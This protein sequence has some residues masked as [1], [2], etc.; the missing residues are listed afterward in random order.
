M[1]QATDAYI[2]WYQAQQDA[3]RSATSDAQ[4]PGDGSAST[5]AEE[6]ALA[7]VAALV[8]GRTS[9]G[10]APATDAATAASEFLSSL[11]QPPGGDESRTR[12]ARSMREQDQPLEAAFEVLRG[13]LH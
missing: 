2:Q 3:K 11:N 10:E 1:L 9:T 13:S 5:T 4:A 8:A 7:K 6:E 12:C